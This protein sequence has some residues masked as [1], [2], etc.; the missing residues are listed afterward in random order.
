VKAACE[1]R[2]RD[3]FSSARLVE[4]F[5]EK[6]MQR[7]RLFAAAAVVVALIV[8]HDF[9]LGLQERGTGP[10]PAAQGQAPA[11]RGGGGGQG[12][13][14]LGDGP[15][16]F[17]SGANRF[18]VV[19]IIK[20]LN[21]PWGLAFAPDGSLLVTERPGR[22]RVVRNGVLDPNPIGGVPAVR[23]ATLGGLLDIALHPRFAEN[24][25]LY[26]AYSKPGVEEP[27]K[28]TTA[29][30]RAKWDGGATLTEV[31][32]I[33]VADAYHGGRGAPGGCCGQGPSDGSYGA[34]L[35]FDKWTSPR[36]TAAA[37]PLPS[38]SGLV[39]RA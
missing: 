19:V 8:A 22:L 28:A 9:S 34:R 15:W 29:V 7:V 20:G 12:A 39:R 35:A 3:V 31:Q 16:E 33:L 36:G 25:L 18:R 10:A 2:T 13:A 4:H 21:R 27:A 23:A 32:D 30:L 1:E 38:L 24:R 6:P 5:E 11:A 17:A 14:P 37:V 26:M